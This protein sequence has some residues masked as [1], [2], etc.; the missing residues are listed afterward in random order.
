[1]TSSGDRATPTLPA[2]SFDAT[3]HFY[4]GLG[5]SVDYRS[6]AWMILSRGGVQLEFFPFPDLDPASSSFGAC[7]RLDDVIG[8]FKIA[9]AAGVPET[10]TGWPRVQRPKRDSSGMTIG[11]LVD[12]DCTLLHLVQ[13]PEQK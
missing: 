10:S 8:F 1:M 13:N 7:L 2:R 6:D 12:P 3:A 9:L 5:F 4:G 11:Y